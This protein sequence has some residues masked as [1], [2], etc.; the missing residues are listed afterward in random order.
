[1]VILI[2]I[3]AFFAAVHNALAFPAKDPR[4]PIAASL[5][6]HVWFVKE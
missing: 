3:L 5:A 4:V 1:M 2:L 6:L